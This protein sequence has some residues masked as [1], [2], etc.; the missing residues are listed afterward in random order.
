MP[1]SNQL[2]PSFRPRASYRKTWGPTFAPTPARSGQD[3]CGHVK[4]NVDGLDAPV[5][6]PSRGQRFLSFQQGK[7]QTHRTV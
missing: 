6:E 1:E 2:L 4:S 5:R 3:P 7:I